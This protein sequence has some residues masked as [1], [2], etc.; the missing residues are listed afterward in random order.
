VE[1]FAPPA[2]YTLSEFDP[3]GAFPDRAYTKSEML[4]YLE[5]A[6]EKLRALIHGLT[7][8]TMTLRFVNPQRDYSR[9]E[10]LLYNMRHVQHHTAQLNLLLRQS[11]LTPPNWVSRTK[12][13]LEG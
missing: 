3:E 6:R 11:G 13:P 1:N 4:G 10:I 2:P 5:F 9:F 8:E 12:H 7:P